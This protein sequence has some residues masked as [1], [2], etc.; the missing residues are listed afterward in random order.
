MRKCTLASRG[1]KSRKTRRTESPASLAAAGVGGSTAG[2]AGEIPRFDTANVM[3]GKSAAAGSGGI[4]HHASKERVIPILLEDTGQTITPGF[5]HLEDPKPPDW[6]A[7]NKRQPP[8]SGGP[9]GPPGSKATDTAAG[10]ATG[11]CQEKVIPIRLADPE[12]LDDEDE[13]DG[14]AAATDR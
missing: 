10:A 8:G 5:S 11:H 2:A 4:S 9:P 1:D 7:F 14:A 12:D 13:E 6:S 3:A